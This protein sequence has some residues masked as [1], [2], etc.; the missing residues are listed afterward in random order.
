MVLNHLQRRFS[1][2]TCFSTG[3][4]IDADSRPRF[5]ELIA[6]FSKMARD[7][8]RYLVIQVGLS[9]RWPSAGWKGIS[10]CPDNSWRVLGSQGDDRMHLPTPTDN[11][12]FRSLISGE[13]MEDAVDADEY[14]VPQHGFFSSPSTSHTPLLHSTVSPVSGQRG[15]RVNGGFMVRSDQQANMSRCEWRNKE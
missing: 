5:R 3:W 12:L 10:P 4:M 9:L 7:P 15:R 1:N 8:S 14:L 2:E 13:D 11:R 6:E